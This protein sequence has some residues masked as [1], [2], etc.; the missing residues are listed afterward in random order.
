MLGVDKWKQVKSIM[1]VSDSYC[2]DCGQALLEQI[3]SG[4]ISMWLTYKKN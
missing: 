4:N 3:K 2:Q 1:C